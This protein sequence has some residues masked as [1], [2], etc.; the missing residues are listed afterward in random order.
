V[1]AC[2][3]LHGSLSVNV[4]NTRALDILCSAHTAEITII[5]IIIVEFIR[6]TGYKLFSTVGDSTVSITMV[7]DTLDTAA[8]RVHR[9]S[10][11]QTT[12]LLVQGIALLRGV[13]YIACGKISY[14]MAYDAY[15]PDKQ[16]KTL[17][18]LGYFYYF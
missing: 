12:I 14:I 8:S 5:T 7:T 2:S 18:E 10:F 15:V 1:T 4:S 11:I 17:L 3:W 16:V 9:E 6:P 13:V